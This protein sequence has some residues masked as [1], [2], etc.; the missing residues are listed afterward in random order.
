MKIEYTFELDDQTL[1]YQV[2]LDRRYDFSEDRSA[3]PAWSKLEHCQCDNCPLNVKGSS[4]CPAA[5]DLVPV[6]HDFQRVGAARRARITVVTP[7]R[8]YSKEAEVEEGLRALMG[9]VMASSACPILSRLKPNARYHLPFSSQQDYTMRSV[10]FYLLRQYFL[11]REGY[12]P[13]WDMLGLVTLNQDLKIVDE[14]LGR[15]VQDAEGEGANI[16]VLRKFF[17]LSSTLGSSLEEQL[18]ALKPLI[19]NQEV[20]PAIDANEKR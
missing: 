19:M 10:S 12:R 1:H 3:L 8:T 16:R 14:A 13:D 17:E 7:E 18:Q 2:D 6:I 15:R 5:V 9:V 20:T 4:H 11:Y